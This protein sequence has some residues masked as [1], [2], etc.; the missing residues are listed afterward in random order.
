MA[1][2]HWYIIPIGIELEFPSH[3]L[4]NFAKFAKIV[5]IAMTVKAT[6]QSELVELHSLIK[7]FLLGMGFFLLPWKTCSDFEL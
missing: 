5:D 2:L 4:S 7:D 1:L 3:L 6:K